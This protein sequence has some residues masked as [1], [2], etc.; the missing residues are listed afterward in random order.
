MVSEQNQKT[1]YWRLLTAKLLP[2]VVE[3]VSSRLFELGATGLIILEET[4]ET[5]TI[6]A[7]F[8]Q[9]SPVNEIP[10]MLKSEFENAG[11]EKAVQS[12]VLSEVE[13]QDWMQ[14]WKE[15]FE[16]VEIGDR[17]VIAPS[18]KLPREPN[19]RIL[20]QIDPGMAFGT[21]SHESTRL[22]LESLERH[23]QGKRLLDVG[24]GTGILSIAAAL[25]VPG[26][27]VT[28]IDIDPD[29]V[30]IARENVIKNGV[31]ESVEV[32]YGQAGDLKARSFDLVVANLTA[33]SIISIAPDLIRRLVPGG[34]L[35]VSGI[36][37][38]LTEDVERCLSALGLRTLERRNSGEWSSLTLTRGGH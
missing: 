23:W 16:P 6:G 18:W 38:A 13:D 3:G 2:R 31:E 29:A 20:V 25:L 34:I 17:L 37:T 22:C 19:T 1:K 28:A 14:K 26:S 30:T 9:D 4:A 11:D 7:Y 32:V 36:L 24:A 8:D 5:I 10:N 21:G 15:G 33:E 27:R 35:I 12:A